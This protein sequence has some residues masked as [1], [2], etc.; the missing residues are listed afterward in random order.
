MSGLGYILATLLCC[1]ARLGQVLCHNFTDVEA[2]GAHCRRT[3][4]LRGI[5]GTIIVRQ[6]SLSGEK[7]HGANFRKTGC[8]A[9]GLSRANG[10]RRDGSSGKTVLAEESLKHGDGVHNYGF[11]QRVYDHLALNQQNLGNLAP[12]LNVKN[13]FAVVVFLTSCNGCLHGN[14]LVSY[15]ILTSCQLLGVTSGRVPKGNFTP[16][17]TDVAGWATVLDR[18]WVGNVAIAEPSRSPRRWLPPGGV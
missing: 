11:P 18:L 6:T 9:Y 10:R 14:E 1:R 4:N 16:Y 12:A 15:W 3:Q 13:R 8:S 5:C 7:K 2:G 17:H